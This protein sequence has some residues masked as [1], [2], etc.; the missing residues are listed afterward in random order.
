M[1]RR[2][3]HLLLEALVAGAVFLTAVGGLVGGLVVAS[4]Q[5]ASASFDQQGLLIARGQIDQLQ[6]RLISHPS[7]NVGVTGPTAVPAPAGLKLTTTVTAV[8]EVTGP[9]RIN[10]RRAVVQVVDRSGR[11]SSLET[12]RW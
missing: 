3:G 4:R 8:T 2:R 7:W 12:L 10:Y 1:R 5:I 6:G 9:V 11:V